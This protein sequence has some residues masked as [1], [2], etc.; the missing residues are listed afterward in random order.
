MLFVTASQVLQE[1]VAFLEMENAAAATQVGF[2][3]VNVQLQLDTPALQLST[4]S[5]AHPASRCPTQTV[6]QC[7]VPHTADILVI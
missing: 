6:F 1:V 2:A 5:Q 7:N 4:V 3:H